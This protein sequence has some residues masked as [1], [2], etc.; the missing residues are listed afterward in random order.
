MVIQNKKMSE[1]HSEIKNLQQTLNIA[2][3]ASNTGIW[4]YDL[5]SGGSGNMFMHDQ[6]FKQVGYT[7]DDFEDDQNVFDLLIHPED[8]DSAYKAIESQQKGLT[9]A[10]E[11]EFRLQA[12][13][14]SWKWILSKG[15]VVDWDKKG[16]PM[17]L[18]GAHLDITERKKAESELRSLQQTLNIALEASNTGIWKIN[19]IT[20]EP[21]YYGDQW[22]KQLGYNR[23]DFS[24]E[25]NI[26]DL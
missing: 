13:D 25:Q 22:F 26:F 19:P 11:T 2:L 17:N 15:Q 23:S 16:L 24:P 14:G 9:E 4:Q 1:T 20:M 21:L 12:K 10:Y 5:R 3:K 7:R 18:T 8:K 6:W